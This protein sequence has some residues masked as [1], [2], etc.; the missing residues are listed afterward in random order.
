M[1]ERQFGYRVLLPE[2]QWSGLCPTFSNLIWASGCPMPD[3]YMNGRPVYFGDAYLDGV[4]SHFENACW[5]DTLEDL[6]DGE[7]HQLDDE[8]GDYLVEQTIEEHGYFRK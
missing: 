7:L 1:S 2:S 4:D 3:T 8:N 6:D 5:A